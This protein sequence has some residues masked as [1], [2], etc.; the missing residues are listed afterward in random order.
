M[1]KIFMA[2]TPTQALQDT[3]NSI[4]RIVLM[5]KKYLPK[6]GWE[7]TEDL[8]EADLSAAHAGQTYGMS[9]LDISHVH[10]L[11]PT[12]S[13]TLTSQWM[14]GANRAVLDSVIEAKRVTVP[15]EWVADLFR[16]D[17]RFSPDVVGWAIE[18]EEW[19]PPDVPGG[20]VLWNK[21][22]PVGVCN[23]EPINK[24][25]EMNP[26]IQFVT[27]F[28][29]PR[30]NEQVIGVQPYD[31]MKDII[32]HAMVY[33]A[34]TRETWG[35]GTVEAMAC[36]VPILGFDW[37]GTSDIVPNGIA[38]I[39][40]EPG[41]YEALN[42]GLQYCIKYRNILGQNARK[43]AQQ[44]TWDKV[45]RRFAQIYDEVLKEKTTKRKIEVSVVIPCYN[46]E[47]YVKAAIDSVKDQ[48]TNFGYEIIVVDDGSTDS[49]LTIIKEALNGF[50]N[51]K[52]IAQ[53]NSK[54]AV[55]RNSGIK[56][57]QGRFIVCLDADDLLGSNEMLQTLYSGFLEHPDVGLTYTGLRLIDSTM[58]RV[59]DSQ[60]PPDYNYDELVKGR[61][62][63]PT[64]CMF[65]KEAWQRTGGYRSRYWT[66]EDADMWLRIGALGYKGK[67]VTQ[68]CMFWYRT[69]DKSATAKIREG[70]DRPSSFIDKTWLTETNRPFA[71]DGKTYLTTWPV[72]NYD[73]PEVSVIIPVGI[74]H[75]KLVIDALDSVE[76]Q[77]DFRWEV[78]V[79][80]DTGK[81]LDLKGFPYARIINTEGMKGAGHAR[82]L[83]IKAATAKLV[84]FL[85]A[86]DM[87]EPEFIEKTL[88]MYIATGNYIY[89]DWINHTKDDKIE[90]HETV[91]FNPETL[92]S[93]GMIHSITCLIPKKWLVEIK[94]FDESMVAWEDAELFFN[95]ASKGYCGTRLAQP[96]FTYRYKTGTRREKAF[97]VFGSLKN[98]VY[99]KYKEF[100]DGEKKVCCNNQRPKIKSDV[101]LGSNL[102]NEVMVRVEYTGPI[103]AENIVGT[104]TK[105][106]YGRRSKGDIFYVYDKDAKA[107]PDLFNVIQENASIVEASEMPGE[108]KL[109]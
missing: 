97:E 56:A 94:G 51:S 50:K 76:N 21:T 32:A 6:Y 75:E 61:N 78:I 37:A 47:K 89:T 39:L 2:P 33:L 58:A 57:S 83:G 70:K 36:G 86:D 8:K 53:E 84:V 85:D 49:S 44:Y 87:L 34:T 13:Q 54:I 7:I 16:R 45:A 68:E 12:Y 43:L 14:Y 55:A 62:C 88:R 48:K 66:T 46:Y 80:N 1:H 109:V 41:N 29:I 31:K 65:R 79:V 24:L 63:V 38:G 42:Q 3:T 100:I 74:G 22:R 15:S 18:P 103:G 4:H 104:Q 92:F 93:K 11:Y 52:I 35:I 23:P 67:K 20:Y 59:E 60:W 77:T 91:D 5:L 64:C 27:T 90:L 107:R 108:P 105:Q 25:A 98:Y 95:L 72:K 69:H 82:N 101:Q 26:K 81:P 96:L 28:G 106:R 9:G 40:V 30:S 71:S 73:Q 17:M 99:N 102:T 10:G 19:Q